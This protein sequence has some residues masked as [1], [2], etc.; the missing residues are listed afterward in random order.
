MKKYNIL[1]IQPRPDEGLGFKDLAVIEPL[2]LEMVAAALEK[3]GHLVAIVDL[4]NLADLPKALQ[5]YQPQLCGINCS[6]TID[7]YRTL[8]IARL[9]F[10]RLTKG[11]LNASI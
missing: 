6:F 11:L 4:F 8:A 9:Y 5:T 7:V 2:G 3:E 10:F 1:L